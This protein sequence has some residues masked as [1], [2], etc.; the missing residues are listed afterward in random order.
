[1]I[2][3]TDSLDKARQIQERAR[4]CGI[5][6]FMEE[7]GGEYLIHLS[8]TVL[9]ER[10]R[11]LPSPVGLVVITGCVLGRGEQE[12]GKT[13]MKSYF[14]HLRQCRPCPKALIFLNGGVALTV[15]GSELLDD[16]RIL[17]EKGTEILSSDTCL[18]FYGLKGSLAVGRTA[19]MKEI[20]ERMHREENT[21]IL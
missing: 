7:S 16:L 11:S 17:A 5:D 10:G 20:V 1:V 12:L 18:D 8:Q 19:G 9:Q 3:L 14:Y 6:A 13:L 15:E 4:E 2:Y 21:L